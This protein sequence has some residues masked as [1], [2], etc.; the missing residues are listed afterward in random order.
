MDYQ[1]EYVTA[2]DEFVFT[3]GQHV[4]TFAGFRPDRVEKG[5][6]K[7]YEFGGRKAEAVGYTDFGHITRINFLDTTGS[8]SS[9]LEYAYTT[10][11]EAAGQVAERWSR[12]STP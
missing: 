8:L 9:F 12:R 11:A 7:S 1:L 5:R 2:D 3:E 10:F 4:W 6:F